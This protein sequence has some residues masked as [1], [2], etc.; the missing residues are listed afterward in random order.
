[1]NLN[2]KDKTIKILN[3]NEILE[4]NDICRLV[5][6]T[7]YE[8]GFDTTFKP[9][10]YKPL[11]WQPVELEMPAWVGYKINEYPYYIHYEFARII[12]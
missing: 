12:N 2:L 7:G 1:M 6:E 10:N 3:E 9:K 11:M 5:V 8:N 4:K